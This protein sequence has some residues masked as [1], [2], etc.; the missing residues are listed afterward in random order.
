MKTT[1]YLAT[2]A[3]G[4]IA[5]PDGD[6]NWTSPAVEALFDQR[7]KEAGCVVVGRKTFEQYQ[8]IIYPMQ[9]VL[10]IVLT[11]DPNVKFEGAVTAPT[12]L[13]A[14]A[15]AHKNGCTAVIIS[16][17]AKT[18][19]A[20]L[21]EDLVSQVFLAVHPLVLGEGLKPFED[22][23]LDANLKLIGT[24]DLGE[25]VVEFYYEYEL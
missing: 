7:V 12:P 5:K 1:L 18:A 20:F 6:S 19:A 23:L 21:N 2:S 11:N 14:L 25:G 15:H 10:N 16:G 9:G 3:D 17:G 22:G 8:G 4:F 13:A 24:K